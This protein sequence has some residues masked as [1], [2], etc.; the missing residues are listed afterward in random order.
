MMLDEPLGWVL[1]RRLNPGEDRR[2]WRATLD[3][4]IKR[5]GGSRSFEDSFTT[6]SN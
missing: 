4:E 3:P 6:S 1:V 5:L 2:R